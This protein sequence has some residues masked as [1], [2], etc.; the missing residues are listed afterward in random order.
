MIEMMI[1]VVIVAV[2]LI[3]ALRV[4]S[5]CSVL[6]SGA[7]NDAIAI[8]ILQEKIDELQE[9][10]VT[11]DGIGKSSAPTE[12]IV[13][14]G[15]KLRFSQKIIAWK[16]PLDEV[17]EEGSEEEGVEKDTGLNEVQLSVNW[18]VQGRRKGLTLK[19][20]LPAEGY[21]QEF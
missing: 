8:D 6:V 19:T 18:S 13:E 14:D 4:F 15:R 11:A 1:T 17:T 21:G 7:Y 2:C 16:D 9:T 12:D 5:I 3:V 10:A 20:L